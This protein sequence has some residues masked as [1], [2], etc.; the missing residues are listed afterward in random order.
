VAGGG[1]ET[2]D[3]RQNANAG[4][5]M[6]RRRDL[7]TLLSGAA[8][9]WPVALHAQRKP[10]PVIGVLDAKAANPDLLT[11]MRKGL[12][13]AGYREGQ[14]VLVKY[15]GADGHYDRL[16]TL[17][18]GFVRNRVAV[19]VA[20]TLP[21]VLAAKAETATIPIVFMLGDDPV[22][23]GLVAS[24]NQPGG[25]ATGLSMLT[26]GLDAKRLELLREL[27][28]SGTRI[29][30]LVNPSN[31][32]IETQIHDVQRAAQSMTREIEVLQAHNDEQIE[33]AFA[34]LAKSQPSGLL[35]GADPFFNSRRQQIVD[36]SARHRIPAIYEWREF[37]DAGGLASYG[38]NLDDNYR[39]LGVYVGKILKGI[40]PA[41]LPVEQ[42]TKFELAINLK[43]AKELGLTV[44]QSLLAR[45]DEVIE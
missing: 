16:P 18:A 10:L 6:P 25:N 5:L 8:I 44:P 33:G 40:K 37:V 38:S 41:D 11:Q 1:S 26:A 24:F 4:H 30:L 28:P 12:A 39:R 3:Q 31:R 19:I 32:N 35:V 2:V 17:A 45:A 42:P 22:K 27:V 23:Q 21:S 36:L 9:A 43:T 20:P 14:D 29:A 13:E 34:T 15:Q 7:F